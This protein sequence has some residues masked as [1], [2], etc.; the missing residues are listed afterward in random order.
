[1][2]ASATMS[3][4][5]RVPPFPPP[6]PPPPPPPLPL[7]VGEREASEEEVRDRD[8]EEVKG[9]IKSKRRMKKVVDWGTSETVSSGAN[10]DGPGNGT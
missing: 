3:L 8:R 10:S 1:M 4:G 7:V 6:V 2:L 5:G 9:D